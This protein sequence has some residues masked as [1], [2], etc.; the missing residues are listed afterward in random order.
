MEDQGPTETPALPAAGG[1]YEFSDEGNTLFGG[2][3]LRMSSLGVFLLILALLD[4]PSILS[5]DGTATILAILYTVTGAWSFYTAYS[6][7]SIVTTEGSDIS[8][9]MVALKSLRGLLTLTVVLVLI[10]LVLGAGGYVVSL[11]NSG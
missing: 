9:L 4:T 5:G 10:L 2:L 3:A 11:F 7:R 8:H 1:P 6:V